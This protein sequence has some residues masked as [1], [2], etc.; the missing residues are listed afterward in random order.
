V[1]SETPIQHFLRALVRFWWMTLLG[2]LLAGVAFVY[3]TYT[4]ALGLPPTLTSRAQ[5]SYS[6]STQLLITSKRDP[7]LSAANVNARIVHYPTPTTTST[8][9]ATQQ[10]YTYDSSGGADGDLQRLVEIAND[11]PPRVTSDPVIALRNKIFRHI[12]GTVSA[13]NPYAF[14]GAGGFSE[15]PLPYIQINGTAS[16]PQDALDITNET[17]VAFTKWFAGQQSVAGIK[18]ADRVL[19]EQVNSADHAVAGSAKKPILGIGAALLVL[20]GVSGIALGLERLM[21]RRP[22]RAQRAAVQA[23]AEAREER[24]LP[25]ESAMPAPEPVRP[26]PEPVLPAVEVPTMTFEP[27]LE[28][29]ELGGEK[30]KPAPRPRKQTTNGKPRRRSS[31]TRTPRVAPNSDD[32]S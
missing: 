3:A 6:A 18:G 26:A 21:P 20:L 4:V 27:K 28:D 13:N 11:L 29:A 9:G 8:S 15:G 31:G 32:P 23:P 30:T 24:A 25:A 19:V 14:S 12:N 17:A 10:A 2:V 1:T 16:S 22:R 5:P 7:Y